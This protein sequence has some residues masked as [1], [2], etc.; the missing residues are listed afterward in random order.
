M[1]TR[2][3]SPPSRA[4][5]KARKH[6]DHYGVAPATG[7][8]V[9]VADFPVYAK[10]DVLAAWETAKTRFL[11]E[12]AELRR[13][14]DPVL[15]AL[16]GM[17]DNEWIGVGELGKRIGRVVDGEVREQARRFSAE[18]RETYA[19]DDRAFKRTNTG[20]AI[21]VGAIRAAADNVTVA[22]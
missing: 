7:T 8:G 19:L 16:D 1:A 4:L 22:A 6:L 10:P 3:W 14:Q 21:N 9:P 15:A 2:R 20:T 13:K 12:Q 11:A 17:G 5:A 18:L